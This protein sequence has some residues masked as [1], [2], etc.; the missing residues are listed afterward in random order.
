MLRIQSLT[1]NP[2]QEQTYV[3]WNTSG[4]AIIIDPGCY[5]P[6]EKSELREFI[7]ENKL[8]PIAVLNTHCHIDHILG[9]A[10]ACN[11]WNIPL[12]VP[13]GEQNQL[14]E[15]LSYGPGMGIFPEASPEPT[16]L[17]SDGMILDLLG[18]NWQVLGIPGHSPDGLC[19]YLETENILIAGDVLFQGSIGRTDLPGGNYTQLL[20]GIM[21]KLMPL[22]DD[23]QVFPGHG[24][25]TRIGVEKIYNPFILD[26]QK[27]K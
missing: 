7:D 11:T 9:N 27:R 19:F 13:A 16:Q 25:P 1:F 14:K 24:E 2:F 22:P 20:S 18:V 21:E 4:Q 10:F 12:F 17:L 23:T 6:E 8:T 5:S 26:W 15:V 3:V